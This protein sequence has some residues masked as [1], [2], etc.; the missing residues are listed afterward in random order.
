MYITSVLYVKIVVK[1]NPNSDIDNNLLR[2]HTIRYI[3]S[4]HFGLVLFENILTFF[5]LLSQILDVKHK[6]IAMLW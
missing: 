2:Q 1:T 6:L 4:S 5:I 3:T